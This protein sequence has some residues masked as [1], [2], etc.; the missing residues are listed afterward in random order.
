MRR[1]ASAVSAMPRVAAAGCTGNSSQA[2]AP[3][4][5]WRR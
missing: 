2:A 4:S 5:P 3:M 1:K